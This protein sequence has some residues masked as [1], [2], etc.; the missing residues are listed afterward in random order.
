MS[1]ARLM[2]V[3]SWLRWTGS[4]SAAPLT[5][6][7]MATISRPISS[8]ASMVWAPMWGVRITFARSASGETRPSPSATWTSRRRRAG[9]AR[10]EGLHQ[11]R[12]VD[13]PA[14]RDVHEG[15]PAS[16]W[17]TP[18]RRSGSR[19]AVAERH[20]DRDEVPLAEHRVEVGERRCPSSAKAAR[21]S[22]VGW[23]TQPI[24]RIPRPAR[25]GRPG[26]RSSRG[27]RSRGACREGCSRR[28]RTSTQWPAR[29]WRS[30]CTMPRARPMA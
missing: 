21:R 25:A 30:A 27:R 29:S 20:M 13:D 14:P 17:R 3:R 15:R 28:A 9:A 8:W 23:S 24:G 6:R 7:M 22:S 11:G 10:G 26:S 2:P 5:R 12:L 18:A 19:V 16:S 4:C 1:V